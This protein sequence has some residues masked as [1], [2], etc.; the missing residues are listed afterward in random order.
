MKTKILLLF[1]LG[2]AG[3]ILGQE[4]INGNKINVN[5]QFIFDDFTKGVEC[6]EEGSVVS[7]AVPVPLPVDAIFTIKG[8][9]DNKYIV[10]F[11]RWSLNKSNIANN[12]GYYYKESREFNTLRTAY[13]N[14]LFD[15]NTGKVTKGTQE[16]IANRKREENTESNILE[17]TERYFLV[18][19]NDLLLNG[20]VYHPIPKYEFVFGTI[21]YLAR[22]RPSVKDISSTWSTDLNLGIAYGV[23][24]NFNKN[25]GLAALGGFSISKIKIDSLSTSPSIKRTI[26]KVSLSPTLNILANYKKFF[27][28]FGIGIDWI[29]LDT[30]EAKKW[31]YNKKPFYAIGIGINLFSAGNND[32]PEVTNKE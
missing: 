24:R 12:L 11:V 15:T 23:R 31:V 5:S 9:S 13:T 4:K 22:I 16:V 7:G 27:V 26:E 1:L 8:K 32:T 20:V 19:K 30:E 25:W 21:T 18:E 2:W 10:K 3:V 17:V 29:N 28:G 6:T 14:T